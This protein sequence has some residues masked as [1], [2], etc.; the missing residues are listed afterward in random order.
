MT[1]E[2][3][4]GSFATYLDFLLISLIYIEL[5]SAIAPSG[6]GPMKIMNGSNI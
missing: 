3:F 6:K 2:I 4:A 5:L 1:S